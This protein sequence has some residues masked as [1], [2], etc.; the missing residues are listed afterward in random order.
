[1]EIAQ[2][3]TTNRD[4]QR[5]V[6]LGLEQVF[7]DRVFFVWDIEDVKEVETEAGLLK[8]RLTDVQRFNVLAHCK[9]NHDANFGM[10]WEVIECALDDLEIRKVV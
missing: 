1:M 7:N 3:L 9:R 4:A 2:A 8:P 6:V 10:N 5:K